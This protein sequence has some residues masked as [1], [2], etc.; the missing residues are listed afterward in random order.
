M[1]R[2]DDPRDPR[3]DA[4]TWNSDVLAGMTDDEQRNEIEGLVT[5]AIEESRRRLGT[6]GPG[7]ISERKAQMPTITRIVSTPEERGARGRRED[8]R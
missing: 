2:V 3:P 1:S 4:R 6:L 5:R 7:D 8:E